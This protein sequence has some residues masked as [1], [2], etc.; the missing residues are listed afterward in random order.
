MHA[1]TLKSLL[2]MFHAEAARRLAMDLERSAADAD[3]V[4][5]PACQVMYGALE[6]EMAGLKPLLEQYLETRVIP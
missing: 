4:D 1:H 6:R 5:W 2:A 3:K